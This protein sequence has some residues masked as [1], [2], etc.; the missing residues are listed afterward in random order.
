MTEHLLLERRGG[1]AIITLN[2]PASLNALTLELMTDLADLLEQLESDDDVAVIVLTGAGRAFCA[3]GDI[4]RMIDNAG[5]SFER[6]LSEVGRMQRVPQR[7]RAMP[8]IVI[9]AVNGVAAGAGMTLAAACDI[10]IVAPGAIFATAFGAVG[11]SGDMGG[12]YTLPRLIGR[13]KALDLYLSGRKIDAQEALEIG[14]IDEI[15]EK[16]CVERAFARGAILAAGPRIA[17]GYMKRNM[18]LAETQPFERMLEIE[19]LH[20]E[21]CVATEYHHRAR[22]VFQMKRSARLAE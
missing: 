16:D 17:Y 15:V 12:S 5:N 7:I 18:F 14:L 4:C 10:R 1:V 21:R 20:Q 9:A 13:A 19:A 8:K 6:N 22:S 11:L 3:G 2:R